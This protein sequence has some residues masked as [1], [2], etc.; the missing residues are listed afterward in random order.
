MRK[1]LTS[2]N[3]VIEFSSEELFFSLNYFN[4]ISFDYFKISNSNFVNNKNNELL[5]IRLENNFIP[6]NLIK[7]Q[8]IISEKNN[9]YKICSIEFSLNYNRD[10]FK[11]RISIVQK[12]PHIIDLIFQLSVKWKDKVPKKILLKFPFLE[13]LYEHKNFLK[14]GY[15]FGEKKSIKKGSWNFHEYPPAMISDPNSKVAVGVEFF[16][17]FPWQAN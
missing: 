10:L 3:K 5:K 13:N 7:I 2:K 16:D 11:G 8:N 1:T 12:K 14:P 17:Q 9:N 4:K 15:I 6:N